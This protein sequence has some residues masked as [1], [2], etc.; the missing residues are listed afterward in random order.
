MRNAFFLFFLF[1]PLFL[2]SQKKELQD[3]VLQNFSMFEDNLI[4]GFNYSIKN[5]GTAKKSGDPKKIAYGHLYLGLSY[6]CEKNYKFAIEEYENALSGFEK[7][8]DTA[9][10]IKCY[11]LEGVSVA[12][13]E[14]P[15]YE[16]SNK[17][18]Q[19]AITLCRE[20]GDTLF[21]A[22]SYHELNANYMTMRKFVLAE[23]YAKK[24]LK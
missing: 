4:T 20:F 10:Q 15:E 8:N 3:T 18:H 22:Y 9:G 11:F 21:P 1:L 19:K 12:N 23:E 17:L 13:K 16:R 24:R 6:A 2:L 14:P 7:I 5:M